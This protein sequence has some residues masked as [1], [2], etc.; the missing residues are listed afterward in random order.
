MN[1]WLWRLPVSDQHIFGSTSSYHLPSR[2]SWSDFS[3]SRLHE[4]DAISHPLHSRIEERLLGDRGCLALFEVLDV[5]RGSELDELRRQPGVGDAL[6]DR[7]A[8]RRARD[9]ADRLSVVVDR[10]A[11]HHCHV[12]VVEHEATELPP[13]PLGLA[14]QESSRPMKSPFSGFTVKPSPAS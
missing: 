13:H 6:P 7:V 9:V 10:I 14:A 1:S 8:V 3:L 5:E 11:A 12:R 2:S 4:R